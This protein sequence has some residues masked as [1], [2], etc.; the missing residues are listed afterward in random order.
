MTTSRAVDDPYAL[1]NFK[2]GR[3]CGHGDGHGGNRPALLQSGGAD[4]RD[5]DLFEDVRGGDRA[6][7]VAGRAGLEFR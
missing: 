5:G 4:A 3:G 1:S 7:G 6:V 2:L